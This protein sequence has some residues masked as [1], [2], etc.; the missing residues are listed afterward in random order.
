MNIKI[1]HKNLTV[2]SIIFEEFIDQSVYFRCFREFNG[3][4]IDVSDLDINSFTIV[5]FAEMLTNQYVHIQNKLTL[6]DFMDGLYIF[7]GI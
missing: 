6:D 7:F 1:V 4:I 3:D 5:H 2:F